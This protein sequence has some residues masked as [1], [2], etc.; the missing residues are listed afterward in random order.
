V[1]IWPFVVAPKTIWS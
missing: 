1:E